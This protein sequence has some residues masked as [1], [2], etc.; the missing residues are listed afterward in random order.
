MALKLLSSSRNAKLSTFVRDQIPIFVK[1][2]SHAE[3]AAHGKSGAEKLEVAAEYVA[4]LFDIPVVPEFIEALLIKTALTCLVELAKNASK[5]QHWL[6]WLIE[7]A[8]VDDLPAE[9]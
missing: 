1:G 6:Q 9:A 7:S 8:G 5:N 3:T 2:I 4:S